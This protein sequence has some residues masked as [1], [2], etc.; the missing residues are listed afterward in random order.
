MR[1]FDLE[2]IFTL[3]GYKEPEWD[4]RL[5]DLGDWLVENKKTGEFFAVIGR[6]TANSLAYKL[7]GGCYNGTL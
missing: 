2:G 7:N 5:N 6:E 4:T 3:G 1:V